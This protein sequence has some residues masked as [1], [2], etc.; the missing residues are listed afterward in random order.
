[1]LNRGRSPLVCPDNS[2]IMLITGPHKEP[3]TGAPFPEVPPQ[4]P[5]PSSS[6]SSI[7]RPN[8][9]PNQR[10]CA[11]ISTYTQAPP[12]AA[13]DWVMLNLASILV[14]GNLPLLDRDG[15]VWLLQPLPEGAGVALSLRKR[16][17]FNIRHASLIKLHVR[18]K[19]RRLFYQILSHDDHHQCYE[20]I[21]S[22]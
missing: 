6:S 13:E 1:M 5:F 22:E 16:R 8:P 21:P 2:S 15:K 3:F 19:S 4:R 20:L 9:P 11:V 10:P 17:D 7:H 14:L 12:S 18:A